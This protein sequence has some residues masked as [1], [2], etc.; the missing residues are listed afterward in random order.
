MLE[1]HH[2]FFPIAFAA[3]R[4]GLRYTAIS[5]RLQPA[6]VDYIVKDCQAKVFITSKFLEETAVN[7]EEALSGV[8]KYMLD[9]TSSGYESY[10]ES[11]A[12]MPEEPIED[13]CQGGS[14]LY[15]S[16]TTG[17]PKGCLLYTSPSPRDRTRSRMPSS[18]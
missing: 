6:E 9:G 5:W 18:A 10:E 14:M 13:E 12:S 16:G 17:R 15:S 2:L 7:L 4:S 11:I 8:K 1:N 3:W